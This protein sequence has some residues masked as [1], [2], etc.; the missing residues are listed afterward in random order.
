VTPRIESIIWKRLD[1]PGHDFAQISSSED[2]DALSGTALFVFHWNTCCLAYT[3]ICDR[4]WETRSVLVTGIATDK[5]VSIDI[6]VTAD[7]RWLFNGT[8]QP[9]VL[10]CIDT[11]LAFGSA[12]NL[13]PIRREKMQIGQSKDVVAAW[14]TFPEL[15]MEPL[16]QTYTRKS[17]SEYLYASSDGRFTAELSVRESGLV[18]N[19]SNLWREE[20]AT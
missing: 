11:D 14:L 15:A 5:P 18:I 10:G 19:Y 17:S 9:R 20:R 6:K 12:T 8:E 1:L 2:G 4:A 7:R 13:L 3:V 16:A